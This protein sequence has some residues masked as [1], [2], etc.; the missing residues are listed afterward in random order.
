M[1]SLLPLALLSLASL[2]LSASLPSPQT[3]PTTCGRPKASSICDPN[4]LLSPSAAQT[5]DGLLNFIAAGSNGNPIVTCGSKKTGFQ[6]A[7]ALI[8]NL[9]PSATAQSY[10]KSLHDSWGVGDAAC[11]NGILLLIALDDRRLYISTGAAAKYFLT[12]DA[13]AAVLS[14]MKPALRRG[15]VDDAVLSAIAGVSRALRGEAPVGKFAAAERDAWGWSDMIDAVFMAMFGMLFCA[16]VA[17]SARPGPRERWRRCQSALTRLEAD[18]EDARRGVFAGQTSCPICLEDFERR[19]PAPSVDGDAEGE[20]VATARGV[21]R[22]DAEGLR[23][24]REPGV[25]AR[26]AEGSGTDEDDNDAPEDERLITQELPESEQ[27]LRCGHKFHREC[28][29]EMLRNSASSDSCPVCRRPMF[30]PDRPARPERP[31][32]SGQPRNSDSADDTPRNANGDVDIDLPS[33][34]GQGRAAEGATWDFFYP[35]YMFRLRRMNHLYPTY[36]TNDLVDRWGEEGYRGALATD[37]AFTRLEPRVVEAARTSG[38]SGASF[39]FGGGSSSG[40]GG[41][42][43]SW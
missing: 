24:R 30:G 15:S 41:A 5:A 23:L 20:D 37:T 14:S 22:G 16:G 2:S 17:G 43:S 36:V 25:A 29:R 32:P 13:A 21:N 34:R 40:G 4:Q 27:A 42:G 6:M 19:S 31:G 28:L 38:A 11:N 3:S 12:D 26:E 39:S 33:G 18:R 7:I 10:A 1:R 35:E 8:R 9:P